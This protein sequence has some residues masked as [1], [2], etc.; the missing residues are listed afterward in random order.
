LYGTIVRQGRTKSKIKCGKHE[1]YMIVQF[2][3]V[4]KILIFGKFPGD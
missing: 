1:K 4:Q 3:T 2:I